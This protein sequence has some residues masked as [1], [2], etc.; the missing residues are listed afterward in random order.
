MLTFESCQTAWYVCF[1][2]AV[3]TSNKRSW[4]LF[5]YTESTTSDNSENFIHCALFRHMTTS[6]EYD[7]YS[8]MR[9]VQQA[10]YTC[11]V[12]SLV[13]A[14]TREETAT[15]NFRLKDSMKIANQE[16]KS[17]VES[18]NA[19]FKRRYKIYFFQQTKRTTFFT[20]LKHSNIMNL[21]YI[22][23]R[24]HEAVKGAL[25]LQGQRGI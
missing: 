21:L 11:H 6:M 10:H 18:K 17:H 1:H 23:R 5:A 15:W 9:T 4:G 2:L 25:P 24:C 20:Y 14:W 22:V 19:L 7:L 8:W 16:P 12:I 3:S 13:S